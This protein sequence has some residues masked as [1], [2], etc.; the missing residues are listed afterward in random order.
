MLIIWHLERLGAWPRRRTK[1]PLNQRHE[2][3]DERSRR[4]RRG[5]KEA[6]SALAASIAAVCKR[7]FALCSARVVELGAANHVLAATRAGGCRVCE[8]GEHDAVRHFPER[9]PACTRAARLVVLADG[10]FVGVTNDAFAASVAAAAATVAAAAATVAAA[11]ATVAAA[12]EA[13]I[14]PSYGSKTFVICEN[15]CERRLCGFV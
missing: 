4:K 7:H 11:A 8:R 10:Q 2:P 13:A 6:A 3:T 1:M 9:S 5:E 12:A 15:E 14:N